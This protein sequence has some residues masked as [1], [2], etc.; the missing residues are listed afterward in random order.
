VPPIEDYEAKYFVKVAGSG[1]KDGSSWDNALDLEG[2][3]AAVQ[4]AKYDSSVFYLAGG[5]YQPASTTTL[6]DNEYFISISDKSL[7]LVGGFAPDITGDAVDIT[8][9]TATPT[10]FS[11]DRNNNSTNDD[12]DCR[13]LYIHADDFTKKVMLRGVT[14]SGGRQSSDDTYRPGISVDG[15]MVDILHCT[16][17]G[18][19]NPHT[20]SNN[21]GGAGLFVSNS[22]SV[23][24]YKTVFT[25]NVSNNRGGAIRMLNGANEL[26]LESCLMQGNSIT[27]DYGSAIAT[28][29]G[30]TYLLNVTVTGN[31]GKMGAAIN[32][33]NGAPVYLISSTVVNNTCTDNGVQGLDIRADGR[34]YACNSIITNNHE[35]G[36]SIYSRSSNGVFTSAG[37]NIFGILGKNS[38]GTGVDA[39]TTATDVLNQSYSAVFGGNTLADNGGYP[40]TIAP[41]GTVAGATVLV[42]E[43][44]KDEY[45]LARGDVSKD[46]RGFTR[47]SSG[48]TSKGAYDAAATND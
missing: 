21:A 35:T 17:N 39:I 11:G 42:L 4:Q 18:N 19:N 47:P 41:S 29:N 5:T 7:T 15:A 13:V 34:V 14:I 1:S 25:N 43:A 40:Q 46:Q 6:H 37:N 31:Q 27:G 30:K 23:Y 10:I 36:S 2:F 8:Y 28:A 33:N 9:P 45:G 12:G 22:S 16:V 3:R 20:T 26:I 24:C 38:S 44:I 48:T 32:V